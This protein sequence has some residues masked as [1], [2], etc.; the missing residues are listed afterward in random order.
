VYATDEQ[1]VVPVDLATWKHLAE[2]VLAAEGVSGDAE[3]S[4]LFVDSD[5]MATLNSTFM[6]ATGPT[7][8]LA[9]PIDA[10]PVEP[11]RHPD[12]GST[13]PDREPPSPDDL[14]MLLG[15]VVICP[16]VADANAPGHA[17]TLDDELALLVVHGVLHVLGHDHAV[18]AD[19]E[20]MQGRERQHLLAFWRTPARDP[21]Q[22]DQSSPDQSSPDQSSPGQSSPGQ[23]SPDQSTPDGQARP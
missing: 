5:A 16:A 19:R 10:E 8:V 14:P 4:L 21:W 3:L 6:G 23:S 7:D 18:D 22:P 11:G 2:Q 17:G 1:D 20:L 12:G 15:D 9:F 13:G